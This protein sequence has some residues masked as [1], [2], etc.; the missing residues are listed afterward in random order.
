V[1]PY[2]CLQF[3]LNFK[4][5]WWASPF[6]P[7]ILYF[8]FFSVGAHCYLRTEGRTDWRTDR[9]K[10]RRKKLIIVFRNRCVD[11]PKI[12]SNSISRQNQPLVS[13]RTVSKSVKEVTLIKEYWKHAF[14][15]NAD[16]FI[17]RPRIRNYSRFTYACSSKLP[18]SKLEKE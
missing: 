14:F 9:L 16:T 7:R 6:K 5:S 8:T 11:S 18:K 12:T 2:N 4:T 1:L 10:D 15:T 13:V 17:A 3:L